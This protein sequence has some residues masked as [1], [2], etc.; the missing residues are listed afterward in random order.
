MG[1]ILNSGDFLGAFFQ[2]KEFDRQVCCAFKGV[3]AY[4]IAP[5]EPILG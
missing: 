1:A 3:Q 5:P 2:S 4:V